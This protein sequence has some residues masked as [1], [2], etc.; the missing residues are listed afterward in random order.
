MGGDSEI[1]VAVATSVLEA[2]DGYEIKGTSTLVDADGNTV[3]QW[4]K[5][6]IDRER[7]EAMFREMVAGMVAEIEPLA[8]EGAPQA[9]DPDLLAVYPVGD[10]HV[11]MYAW[12]EEAGGDYNIHEAKRLL[13]SSVE[14]LSE[15]MPRAREALVVILGDFFHYDSL[16]PVTPTAKNQL[17]SDGRFPLMVRTGMEILRRV[18]ELAKA[19]HELVHLI[20]QAGNHDPATAVF[21]AES[22]AM[23]YEQEPRVQ[24]DTS[25]RRFH[26]HEHGKALI[27]VCHGHERRKLEDLA[28]IM[29]EDQREAWGRTFHRYW[30]T[31]HVH[32]DRVL[33]VQGTRI[34]S[35]RILPPRDAWAEG[36]GYRGRS[37]M[38]GIV[39]HAEHGE[40]QRVTV[41]PEMFREG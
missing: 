20:V 14:R 5:T 19:R 38:K 16:D 29:A 13:V 2:P 24:V 41:N 33:D 36:H 1:P 18:V 8:P 32:K 30:Y 34:E 40:V 39:I 3:V 15:S 17:D 26:Y 11:G 27:G 25:P 10:H 35:F 21:L 31:G 22:F 6:G 7:Q 4:I 12:D 9:T 28:L 23:L 37:E